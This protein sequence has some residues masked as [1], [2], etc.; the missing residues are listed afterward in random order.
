[1]TNGLHDNPNRLDSVKVNLTDPGGHRE[2]LRV[3][4]PLVLSTA[5]LT[6]MLFV[7]R[8][9]LSWYS[10]SAVAASTPGGITYF[11]IC[12]FFLG[13]AQYVNAIV[14]QHHGAGEKTACS[15]AVWQGVLFSFMAA[16]MILAMI[17]VGRAALEW[18]NHGPELIPLEKEFFTILML[19]GVMLPLNAAL[20]S[21]FSG[22]GL[23]RVVMWGNIMGNA[24]NAILDYILIFGKLGFPEL[25]IKGAGLATAMTAALPTVYWTILFLSPRY[26]VEYKT[27]ASLAFDKRLFMMLLKYGIPSGAQFFLDISSFTFFILL[28]GRLGETSLAASNIVL[29]I[30][31]LSFL[32]MVGMSIATSTLVG[33]YI[34]RGNHD[35]AAKSVRSAL[36][37]ALAY[38]I[39]LAMAYFFVP[40]WFISMFR[41]GHETAAEFEGI[42]ASGSML[43]RLV[44]VYTVFDTVFIIYSG[45]L[46][47][48][49]D[50]RFAMWAQIAI[51]W[52]FFVP[53]VYFITEYFHLGLFAA[54]CW[55]VA[56][57]IVLGL[58]FLNRFRSGR[59][60]YIDM[61]HVRSG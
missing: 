56:Y 54:W 29:S 23:T 51:A 50:T 25:G 60:K 58:V 48:A 32:P 14:A 33:E 21:F 35:L 11:T 1:M 53:P 52:F 45:A 27:R 19:G 18:S 26:Q 57:V 47:G 34:G 16:P 36:N 12:S 61:I 2:V 41:P 6:V 37:M 7:D 38:T 44:A 3:A 46:K 49:G 43:L 17:P 40:Q 22:R 24:A 5:S 15:R 31:T 13:I 8:L 55:A 4:L 59:W 10:Q 30:E 42:V 39:V 20:S 9:F 28:I